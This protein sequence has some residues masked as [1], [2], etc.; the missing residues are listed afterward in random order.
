M[1]GTL[2][3][4][5]YGE[6]YGITYREALETIE[7]MHRE[8]GSIDRGDRLRSRQDYATHLFARANGWIEAIRPFS[9]TALRDHKV[10]DRESAWSLP[11]ALDHPYYFRDRSRRAMCIVSHHYGVPE[12]IHIAVQEYGLVATVGATG[13]SWYWPNHTT[14]VVWARPGVMALWPVH[15]GAGH[16]PMI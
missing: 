14:P 6:P 7:A 2:L 4:D 15:A 1:R 11:D 13:D 8:P 5:N 3:R 16:A 10:F 12:R 9:I